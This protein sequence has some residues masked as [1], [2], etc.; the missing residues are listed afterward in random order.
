MAPHTD[1]VD[2][3]SSDNA[4]TRYDPQQN[5]DDPLLDSLLVICKLHNIITSRNALTAGLPLEDNRLT[6]QTFP[7]AA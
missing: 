2:N 3:S 6:S 1:S 4:D 7:R 5:H